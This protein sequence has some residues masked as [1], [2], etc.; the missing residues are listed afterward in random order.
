MARIARPRM[1]ARSAE[2]FRS[3][4]RVYISELGSTQAAICPPRWLG[5]GADAGLRKIKRVLQAGTPL[6]LEDAL[7]LVEAALVPPAKNI[8]GLRSMSDRDRRKASRRLGRALTAAEKATAIVH[9]EFRRYRPALAIFPGQTTILSEMLVDAVVEALGTSAARRSRM[10]LAM[11]SRVLE[12]YER[13][14]LETEGGRDLLA[15]LKKR[16]TV[17]YGWDFLGIP[18]EPETGPPLAHARR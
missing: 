14:L 11:F 9:V 5:S 17:D 16:Q 2:R 8:D 10:L 1:D 12:P 6:A 13:Q 15:Y 18:N 3:H 7:E 4:V